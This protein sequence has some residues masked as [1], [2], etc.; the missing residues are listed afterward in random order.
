MNYLKQLQREY[1]ATES[2]L[3]RCH[4]KIEAFKQEIPKL[5][6][7]LEELSEIIGVVAQLDRYSD[8]K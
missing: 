6:S 5:E 4:E 8:K 3:K 2:E 1:K 7:K